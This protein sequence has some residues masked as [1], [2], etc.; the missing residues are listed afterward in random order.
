MVNRR[1]LIFYR[2]IYYRTYILL[3][4]SSLCVSHRLK[5]FYEFPREIFF[6]LIFRRRMKV[7]LLRLTFFGVILV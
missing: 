4:E 5:A 1:Y 3:Y 2:F 7:K 6:T